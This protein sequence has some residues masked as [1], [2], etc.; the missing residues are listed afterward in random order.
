MSQKNHIINGSFAQRH[1]DLRHSMSLCHP[2]RL[3]W[4]TQVSFEIDVV[5]QDALRAVLYAAKDDIGLFCRA[6]L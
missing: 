5:L 2:V 1:R 6:L 3:F 4:Y